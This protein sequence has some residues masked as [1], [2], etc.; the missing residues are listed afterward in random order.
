MVNQ[1]EFFETLGK[2]AKIDP[3]QLS[4]ET[5]IRE[6]LGAT[7]Q[8]LFSLCALVGRM[9]GE[10]VSYADVNACTTLGEVLALCEA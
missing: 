9:S 8:T 4:A 3:S 6:D 5:R 7:S 1:E 10:S 2:M